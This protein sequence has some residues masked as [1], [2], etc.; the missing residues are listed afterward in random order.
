MNF[1]ETWVRENYRQY[2]Q[3]YKKTRI[4]NP[5]QKLKGRHEILYHFK[6]GDF[7][8]TTSKIETFSPEKTRWLG[9]SFP[10][11]MTRTPLGMVTSTTS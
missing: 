2:R 4:A 10:I 3:I 9:Y 1:M 6:K 8:M 11:E 7:Q 5:S